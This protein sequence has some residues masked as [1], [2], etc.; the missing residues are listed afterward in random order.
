MPREPKTNDLMTG[1]PTPLVQPTE[2]E[3]RAADLES[4]EAEVSREAQGAARAEAAREEAIRQA[5][6]AVYLRKGARPG[7]DL[8]DWLEAERAV[9]SASSAVPRRDR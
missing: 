6:Y 2:A 7:G 1:A 5:A 8:D 3:V 9:D 4:Q